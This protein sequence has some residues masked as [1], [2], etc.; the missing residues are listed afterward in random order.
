MPLM[1]TRAFNRCV[2]AKG[3][4]QI[5]SDPVAR[6]AGLTDGQRQCEWLLG[7]DKRGYRQPI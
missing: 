5:L 7:E 2:S 4:G 6:I 3:G 1:S